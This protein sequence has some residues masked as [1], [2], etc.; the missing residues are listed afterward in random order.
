MEISEIR[1]FL[2]R[3]VVSA[4]CSLFSGSSEHCILCCMCSLKSVLL[5]CWL[6]IGQTF[7]QMTRTK[8]KKKSSSLFRWAL[9]L[10]LGYVFNSQQLS[11]QLCLSF[12]FLLPFEPRLAG[13]G[14]LRLSH[15]F[16]EHTYSPGHGF[17]LLD[18]QEYVG[19]FQHPYGH[20]F[21][22]SFPP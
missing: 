7:L 19:T 10:F 16:P 21:L 15:I 11:W 22:W 13:S 18:S 5:A 6:A 20:L 8:K 17:G 14:I 3:F 9:Y 1:F 2:L 12:C 4:Y